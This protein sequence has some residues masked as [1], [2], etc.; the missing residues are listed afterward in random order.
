[1]PACGA[2]RGRRA[3]TRESESNTAPALHSSGILEFEIIHPFHPDR[4]RRLTIVH[5]RIDRGVEWIWYL[6]RQGAAR[7][8]TRAFTDLAEPDDFLRQAAGRCVFQTR[9]LVRLVS[10]V[11]RLARRGCAAAEA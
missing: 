6:D 3:C 10:V 8:V 1:L 2:R 5:T 11:E 4:G 7:Q 9:D